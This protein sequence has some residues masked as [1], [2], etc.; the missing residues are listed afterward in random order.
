M[1][2]ARGTHL[3]LPRPDVYRQAADEAL[4][5][6]D[7]IQTDILGFEARLVSLVA[8]ARTLE[9]LIAAL[10]DLLGPSVEV[11]IPYSPA[12]AAD[13]DP[14]VGLSS[15]PHRPWPATGSGN[16]DAAGAEAGGRRMG[17]GLSLIHISEPTRRTPIS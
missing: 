9:A 14:S 12:R 4:A 5:E 6:L 1:D 7:E 17:R 8:R 13:L 16:A 11:M 15:R 2:D 10:H 3:E